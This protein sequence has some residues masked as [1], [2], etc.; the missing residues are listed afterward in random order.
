MGDFNARLGTDQ[1][2][3]TYHDVTNRNGKHMAELLAEFGLLA[4]NTMFQK[5]K[6]KLWTFKDRASDALRQ[7]DYILVRKKWRNSVHNSEAYNSFKTV[8]SDHRVVSMI[9]EWSAQD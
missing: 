8:G 6:G 1:A 2:P 4:T 5:K 9:I 7:L 3:Y